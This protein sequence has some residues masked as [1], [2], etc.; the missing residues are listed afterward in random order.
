MKKNFFSLL[1]IA[2]FLM[3]PATLF[4]EE[5]VPENSSQVSQ[6]AKPWYARFLP[7]KPINM[8]MATCA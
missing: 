2:S 1:I 6:D 8:T 7:K 3:S 5:T 4:A